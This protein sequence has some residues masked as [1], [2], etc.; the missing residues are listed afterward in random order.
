MDASMRLLSA[1]VEQR[2]KGLSEG[3]AEPEAARGASIEPD[4]SEYHAAPEY[5]L[6]S[7]DVAPH[8][9]ETLAARGI[10]RATSIGLARS[11][12]G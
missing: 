6:T 8:P 5:L 11:R 7:G 9:N 3:D 4:A 1:R 12:G 2:K 10:Y